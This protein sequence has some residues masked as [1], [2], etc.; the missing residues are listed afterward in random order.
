MLEVW[1]GWSPEERT[2][3]GQK[4]SCTKASLPPSWKA[5]TK[6][7]MLLAWSQ[8][9]DEEIAAIRSK[10]SRTKHATFAAMT[11]EQRAVFREKRVLSLQAHSDDRRSEVLRKFRASL[12]ARTDDQR[13]STRKKWSLGF[14][15]RRT[16]WIAALRASLAKRTADFDLHQRW[17]ANLR[18]SI[19]RRTP[20]QWA[21]R[22]ARLWERH[23]SRPEWSLQH[24]L[25][26]M[27][28]HARKSPEAR[29]LENA[30]H[31]A[32]CAGWTAEFREQRRANICRAIAERTQEARETRLEK[33]RATQAAKT[34]EEVEAS[35]VR[36]KAAAANMSTETR[37]SKARKI[38]ESRAKETQDQKD[39][40]KETNLKA[41]ADK[42]NREATEQMQ[43]LR[44]GE[45]TAEERFRIVKNGKS[46]S[47]YQSENASSSSSDGL[48]EVYKAIQSMYAEQPA[49][50][51]SDRKA[52]LGKGRSQEAAAQAPM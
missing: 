41:I 50:V 30:K 26:V 13:E 10:I 22:Y 15:G 8:K 37:A 32:T 52:Y 45:M 5:A 6:A 48:D 39:A 38:A 17:I 49:L 1:S 14:M 31:R 44:S 36:R 23:Y 4:T 34:Q 28:M 25:R 29:A 33:F 7:R 51:Q 42:K 46:R 27:A 9:T 19:A 12:A 47:K 18:A 11:E 20:E 40:R 3:I 24:S 21:E 2:S 43:R 35:S 16:R